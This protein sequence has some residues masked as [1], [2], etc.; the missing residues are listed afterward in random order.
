M[1]SVH[2]VNRMIE[3]KK[4]ERQVVYDTILQKCH[5]Y[6]LKYA[7]NERYRCFFEVPEF[8]LGTPVYNLNAAI[9]FLME[10]LSKSGFLIKYFFPNYLYI[11]WS[12]DEIAGKRIMYLPPPPQKIV[13]QVP[14]RITSTPSQPHMIGGMFPPKPL[15]TRNVNKPDQGVIMPHMPQYELPPPQTTFGNNQMQ[16]NKFIKSIKDYRP[17]GKFV[18]DLT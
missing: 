18:L 13:Q 1:L 16:N 4:R 6:I 5:K 11:S 15:A 2:D 14:P 8:M 3:N 7:K 12:V 9:T 17:S 10:K